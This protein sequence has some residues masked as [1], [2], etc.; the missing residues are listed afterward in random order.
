MDLSLEGRTKEAADQLIEKLDGM[1]LKWSE[2][3]AIVGIHE[4]EGSKPTFSGTQVCHAGLSSL[5]RC[6][7]VV[8]A[9]M[10]GEGYATG[11][12][13]DKEVEWWFVDYI[14][15]RSAYAES[16]VTKDATVALEQKYTVSTGD[17]P[18]NLMA[19]GMVALRR[20]WEYTYV[21]KAA[22]DLAKAGV[23]EDLAFLLGHLISTADN[24]N[25]ASATDWRAC[26]AGHCSL[27]PSYMGWKE[28]Q[29]FLAHKVTVPNALYSKGGAYRN[30]DG[31]YGMVYDDTYYTFVHN[32]FPYDKCKEQVAVNLNPF[33]AACVGRANTVPYSAAIR[34]MAEWANTV[35]M[36]KINNA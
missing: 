32:S 11:R 22:Y 18:G 23:N 20:L 35:L 13:L 27:R 2:N 36:E 19:A 21:A 29:N 30:Y 15:N 1:R 7:R 31:M 25:D 4:E 3:S 8:S 34:V 6:K 10:S 16:F 5:G 9:L 28:V 33:Q 24:P 17:V 26:H 12:V 14:L